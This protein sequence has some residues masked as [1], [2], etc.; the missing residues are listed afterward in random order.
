MLFYIY[1]SQLELPKHCRRLYRVSDVTMLSAMHEIK[2]PLCLKNSS[3]VNCVCFNIKQ[4]SMLKKFQ[5]LIN[6]NHACLSVIPADISMDFFFSLGL[7]I[8]TWNLVYELEI[9]VV[10]FEFAFYRVWTYFAGVIIVWYNH[11][12]KLFPLSSHT[13]NWNLVNDLKLSPDNTD[14]VRFLLRLFCFC[15]S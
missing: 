12:P 2:H 5:I 7:E 11:F 6:F 15:G 8:L 14:R 4:Y 3:N 13:L 9:E 10:P 1:K